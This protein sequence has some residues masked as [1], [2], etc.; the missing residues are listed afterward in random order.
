MVQKIHLYTKA[1]S[2]WSEDEAHCV[3]STVTECAQ[4]SESGG[5]C[6]ECY[7]DL[8]IVAG[9]L[10]FIVK[11]ERREKGEGLKGQEELKGRL[12]WRERCSELMRQ[13]NSWIRI[14]RPFVFRAT[15]A[16][17]IK[18][19][20]LWFKLWVICTAERGIWIIC[21]SHDSDLCTLCCWLTAFI[22]TSGE[23]ESRLFVKARDISHSYKYWFT[24]RYYDVSPSTYCEV[25]KTA[26]SWD[27]MVWLPTLTWAV[28]AVEDGHVKKHHFYWKLSDHLCVT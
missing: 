8:W 12:K 24:S 4:E 14:Y 13:I 25:W 27:K 19:D 21:R 23:R 3:Y 6:G 1:A 20:P 18:S 2:K 16:T 17:K 10:A 5:S 11:K 26:I 9:P 7:D 15:N 28:E 22:W